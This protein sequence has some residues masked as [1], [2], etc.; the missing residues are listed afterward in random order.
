MITIRDIH[1]RLKL[2]PESADVGKNYFSYLERAETAI[3][4]GNPTKIMKMI[5]SGINDTTNSILL[6]TMLD[7]YDA[8]YLNGGNAAN[9]RH[10]GHLI[11]EDYV[12]RTRDAKEAQTYLKIA[13][14]ISKLPI[15]ELIC[16]GS[17]ITSIYEYVK[18]GEKS[19][20]ATSI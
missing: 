12:A 8:L 17:E 9:I 16:V 2:L 4:S 14:Y 19:S 1:K 15:D 5:E 10:Y 3:N 18:T 6:D 7:L 20:L 13:R 11:A